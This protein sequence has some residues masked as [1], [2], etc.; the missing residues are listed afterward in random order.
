MTTMETI[1][2][3]NNNGIHTLE[4]KDRVSHEKLYRFTNS[5][6]NKKRKKF[7]FDNCEVSAVYEYNYNTTQHTLSNAN[8][9]DAMKDEYIKANCLYICVSNDM[10]AVDKNAFYDIVI[11]NRHV[12]DLKILSNEFISTVKFTSPYVDANLHN[13]AFSY[14]PKEYMWD[15]FHNTDPEMND[16]YDED[17]GKIVY[18]EKDVNEWSGYSGY[19]IPLIVIAK[20]DNKYIATVNNTNVVVNNDDDVLNMF[21]DTYNKIKNNEIEYEFG[22]EEVVLNDLN[23]IIE[24]LKTI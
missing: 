11:P 8:P 18:T 1:T 21:V 16:Y 24:A 4:V 23:T 20:S 9:T 14:R 17:A 10:I 19:E 15:A 2:L 3:T 5:G 7:S 12:N 13:N 6:W 22:F